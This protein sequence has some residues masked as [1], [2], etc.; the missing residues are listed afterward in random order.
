MLLELASVDEGRDSNRGPVSFDSFVCQCI[1]CTALGIE[2]GMPAVG[3]GLEWLLVGADLAVVSVVLACMHACI[4][5][6]ICCIM[7]GGLCWKTVRGASGC[8]DM[9][10]PAPPCSSITCVKE[11]N[12]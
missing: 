12:S 11:C 2:T 10:A 8:C 3:V 7:S 4:C 6:C 5:M 1:S 9:A